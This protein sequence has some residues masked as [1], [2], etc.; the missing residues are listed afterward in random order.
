[1]WMSLFSIRSMLGPSCRY[2][3]FPVPAFDFQMCCPNFTARDLH[4]PYVFISCSVNQLQ[5]ER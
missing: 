4:I 1:V 5:E 2:A 3:P